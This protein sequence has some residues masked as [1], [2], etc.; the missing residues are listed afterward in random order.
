MKNWWMV[1]GGNHT[2][3]TKSPSHLAFWEFMEELSK[4]NYIQFPLMATIK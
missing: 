3:N 4:Q 2:A 1:V